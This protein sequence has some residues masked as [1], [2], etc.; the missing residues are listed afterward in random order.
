MEKTPPFKAISVKDF[1]DKQSYEFKY[2]HAGVEG[3]SG[4]G[5]FH[6]ILDEMRKGEEGEEWQGHWY[7]AGPTEKIYYSIEML[8]G[9]KRRVLERAK[10]RV[11]KIEGGS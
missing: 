8:E 11:K 1:L 3:L 4:R 10:D 5:V 9:C 2:N 7:Q 6:T